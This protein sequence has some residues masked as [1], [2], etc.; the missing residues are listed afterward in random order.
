MDRFVPNEKKD[1]LKFKKNFEEKATILKELDGKILEIVIVSSEGEEE[2]LKEADEA[3]SVMDEIDDKIIQ[4]QLKMEPKSISPAISV[5]SI[6]TDFS[7]TS[8]KAVSAKLPKL[9]L[10]QFDGKPQNWFE[11]WDSFCSAVEDNE[12]LSEAVK[13]QYLR[14]SLLEPARSVVSGFKITGENYQ[15]AIDLLKQRYARPALIKRAHINEMLNA[16]G[17][18][19]ERNVAKMKSLHDKVETHL[20]GLESMGTDQ[21]TFA[22]IVVPVLLEKIPQ[23]V[24][25]NMVRGAE[26]SHLEWNVTDFLSSLQKELDVRELHEPIFKGNPHSTEEPRAFRRQADRVKEGTA[27]ALLSWAEEKRCAFC[28]EEHHETKCMNVKDINT[29]KSIL[30]KYGRCFICFRKGHRAMDFRS[31][32]NCSHC[33]KRH[34]TAL[35]IFRDEIRQENHRSPNPSSAECINIASCV[36]ENSSCATA[37]LQTAQALINGDRDL[38]VH[39]IFD[40]GSQKSFITARAAEMAGLHPIR[41][42]RLGIKVF[43]SDEGKYEERDLVV[44]DLMNVKGGERVRMPAFIV[45]NISDIPYIHVESIKK[46]YKH[47][48]KIW[49]SDVDSKQS[50][51]ELDILIGSNFLW[52][53]QGQ[54]TIRGGIDEPVAVSTKLGWVISGPL[55]GK[56]FKDCATN[57]F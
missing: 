11:F 47:L 51:L 43:G 15:S 50:R 33:K 36:Q 3:A 13:F 17:V 14:K 34:N 29:R 23:S 54:Q 57:L 21:D 5:E 45:D 9:E 16:A 1:L 4:I 49:F 26:K 18:F 46:G 27:T 35:C 30:K 38:R 53:F 6:A 55:K 39:V 28:Q 2:P 25:L 8:R 24:R 40:S 32:V 52:N 48:P 12:D 44:F 31:K 56:D 22:S 7:A 41:R 42:K 10:Q 20:R 19:N 37:A